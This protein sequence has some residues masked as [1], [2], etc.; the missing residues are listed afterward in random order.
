VARIPFT[1][2]AQP[3]PA[4]SI[5]LFAA[6]GG[7]VVLMIVSIT[8]A[9]VAQR[10][11]RR[12]PGWAS[13]A[14]GQAMFA[15][16]IA[17]A[18]F[19]AQQFSAAIQGAQAASDAATTGFGRPHA[20]MAVHTAPGT[21]QAG[22]P[23]T[24]TIDLSDGATG[25][26][27]DDL[28]PHHEALLHLVVVSA[29]GAFY[30]HVHPPRVGPGRYAIA[31]TPDRPGRFSAYA[32]IQRQD[33][34]AQLIVRDFDVG[35]AAVGPPARF[36]G[37]GSRSIDGLDVNVAS[38][39]APPKAGRQATLTFSFSQGGRPVADLQP[40]LGMGGH[41]IARSADGAIFAHVHAAGPMAP[42]AAMATSVSY[43]PDISFVYTF[44]QPG[45][46]QVWGQF[47]RAG[48]IVT[49]PL[50]VVVE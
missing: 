13:W 18:I 47:R 21:A 31:L 12:P 42:S 6:L 49:V 48:T 2:A 8:L 46:Y 37:L 50:E 20:N 34:G 29:D 45:R 39:L 1:I 10:R 17:A 9:A 11:G 24:L 35:G 4:G 15:C 27:I 3:L 22:Q 14:I 23:I 38:S 26:P 5:G 16:L 43:G 25:L 36:Q 33:S 7:L 44:P 32:E 40:W 30:A 28:V 19:G 41:L